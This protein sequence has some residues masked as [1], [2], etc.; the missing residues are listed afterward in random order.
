MT[1]KQKIATIIGTSVGATVVT[2][3]TVVPV[4][5]L[6]NK[7]NN[8]N[9]NLEINNNDAEKIYST[10][11]ETCRNLLI[12]NETSNQ[13][14]QK[15]NAIES[16]ESI[17]QSL[18]NLNNDNIN[19]FVGF[20][21]NILFS[22]I[23]EQ[24]KTFNYTI[25]VELPKNITFNLAENLFFKF[26]NNNLTSIQP[27]SFNTS[28]TLSN[29]Q[30]I[31][32]LIQQYLT[33]SQQSE[34]T[35][36]RFLEL[37]TNQEEINAL[38][39]TINNNQQLSNGNELISISFNSEQNGAYQNDFNVTFTVTFNNNVNGDNLSDL[40]N[41]S[42]NKMEI[43]NINPISINNLYF[44]VENS[45]S[46]VNNFQMQNE[47]FKYSNAQDAAAS[48]NSLS[49]IQNFINSIIT[50][51]YNSLTLTNGT[52]VEALN[53]INLNITLVFDNGLYTTFIADVTPNFNDPDLWSNFITTTDDNTRKT[54]IIGLTEQGKQQT[55][56]VI[57]SGVEQ[58]GNSSNYDPLSEANI[59][60]MSIYFPDTVNVVYN[61]I[62]TNSN[63]LNLKTVYFSDKMSMSSLHSLYGFNNCPNL[64]T[65]IL[66]NSIKN[67]GGFDNC[68]L[69]NENNFIFSN[70][71]QSVSGF[72][73]CGFSKINIPYNV[74][75]NNFNDMDSVKEIVFDANHSSSVLGISDSFCNLPNCEKITF[76]K[77]G[78]IVY[79]RTLPYGNLL[80]LK[81][82]S[83]PY[84][85]TT[86]SNFERWG[87]FNNVSRNTGQLTI[88]LSEC[89]NLN[90]Q[91]YQ[92]VKTKIEKMFQYQ[93]SNYLTLTFI[94]PTS[95]AT[96]IKNDLSHQYS[97][98][99]ITNTLNDKKLLT[100]YYLSTKK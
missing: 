49:N 1:K 59:N 55:T 66:P 40:F 15:L 92:I 100:T 79:E 16:F 5:L 74:C 77:N 48:L 21:N 23:S 9:T 20:M 35:Y 71:L 85:L 70:S 11:N 84:G 17:K 94:P 51:E 18:L 57:P 31:I 97:N 87:A 25:D 46:V 98:Y 82:I 72:D 2:I 24:D 34:R 58:I 93:T 63:W 43:T 44:L 6:N 30:N 91:D 36:D 19:R 10:I 13:I 42:S 29:P 8:A 4:V 47:L 26:E 81:E 90:E 80:N 52:S 33:P 88:N 53:G 67:L 75:F 83:F 22:N 56:I 69:I 27:I 50:P 54:T 38:I 3:A 45:S 86:N 64:E 78:I 65:V 76:S 96:L 32:N 37:T 39:Q 73:G 41:I 7:D 12:G 95:F 68:S 89:T 99:L 61:G 28:I 14:L 60:L 62:L